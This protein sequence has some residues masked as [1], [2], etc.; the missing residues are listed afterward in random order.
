VTAIDGT[1]IAIADSAA[2]RD[3]F[4]KP[5]GGPN[6]EAGYP[7]IRLIVIVAV[8]TRSV[9]EAVFGPDSTGELT[10]ADRVAA[11]L[12]PGMLLLADRNFATSKF[13]TTITGTRADFLIRAKTGPTA[14]KLPVID[15]LADG[16][17]L[18]IAGGVRVR[19]IDAAITA[20]TKAGTRTGHYRLITTLLDPAEAPADAMVKLYHQRW[21]IETV[22]YEMKSTVLAGRVLRGRHPTAVIQEVWAILTAYQ[23]LRTAMTDALGCR[24]DV[25]PDRACFT[26]A[27]T[28][29]R[30]QIVQAA[31]IITGAKT[32]L[33]G[34]IGAAILTDLM[35]PRRFRTRPRAIKR[36]IS[37]CRAKTRN[38]DRRS[39]PATLTTKILTLNPDP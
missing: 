4:P 36:A 29:A 32:D 24:S 19:V 34:R 28:S 17:Y 30:D 31:G 14:M 27:L 12:R 21:E 23:V 25:D 10:Y 8:G 3:R 26:T 16:S 9:I 38:T 37:K 18:S 2:N 35:P 1:Q 22:F 39:Y 11:A 15:R 7:M 6:G 5:R 20:T 33:V 13:Y